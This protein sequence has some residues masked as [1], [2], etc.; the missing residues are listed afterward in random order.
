M[1]DSKPGATKDSIVGLLFAD[2]EM[3][4]ES[5]RRVL[6]RFPDARADFRPHP[7][8]RTAAELATHVA[9]VVNRGTTVLE[10]DFL[11][12]GRRKLEPVTTAAGL[13]AFFDENAARLRAALAGADA[14]RLAA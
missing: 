12:V 10:T 3:E 5:T 13:V 2:L 8:S 6:E 9:D 1:T 7:K 11:E 4:L 14:A